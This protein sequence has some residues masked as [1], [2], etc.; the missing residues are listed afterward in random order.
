MERREEEKES[1]WRAERTCHEEA[2][3]RE[4]DN[5]LRV[6]VLRTLSRKWD[7]LIKPLPWGF[8]I[9]MEEEAEGL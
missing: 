7:V 9:H 4:L 6:R 5:V 1:E 3:C 2:M 8:L